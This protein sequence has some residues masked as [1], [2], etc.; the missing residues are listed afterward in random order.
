M[1]F[2][3]DET[4]AGTQDISASTLSVSGKVVTLIDTPGFDDTE[5]S[6]ADILELISE[7]L[8]ETYAQKILLTGIIL[9]QP[10]TG[11]RVKGSEKRRVLLF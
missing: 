9:L 8:L 7:Y 5:R 2:T 11:N 3:D 4:C 10:V 6:D 1:T